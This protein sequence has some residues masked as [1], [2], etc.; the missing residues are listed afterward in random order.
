MKLKLPKPSKLTEAEK[1]ALIMEAVS[2]LPKTSLFPEKVAEA[3]A[4][5]KKAKFP[6]SFSK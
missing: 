3:K 6:P 5:L 4:F 2:K 1:E